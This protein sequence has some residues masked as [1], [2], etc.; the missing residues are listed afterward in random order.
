MNEISFILPVPPSANGRLVPAGK[1]WV[2]SSRYRAWL[3]EAAR[4]TPLVDEHDWTATGPMMCRILVRWQ[5]RRR[6][7]LDNAVKPILD[8]LEATGWVEDDSQIVNLHV[9]RWD[10]YHSVDLEPGTVSVTLIGD[11]S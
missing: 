7:D 11:P 5:D 2:N 6:R 10:S 1:R 4:I 9:L 3:A 8:N